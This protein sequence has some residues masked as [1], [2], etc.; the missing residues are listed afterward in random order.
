M[1]AAEAARQLHGF[2]EVV[3]ALADPDLWRAE[4][5]E[6]FEGVAGTGDASSPEP[7]VEL[8]TVIENE[9]DT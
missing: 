8:H 3:V 2:N 7:A 9:R 4:W 6:L 5:G 1:R